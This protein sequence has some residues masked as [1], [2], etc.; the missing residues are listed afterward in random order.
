MCTKSIDIYQHTLFQE[1]VEML[2]YFNILYYIV[3]HYK[4]NFRFET[5]L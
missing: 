4:T 1:V 3:F 2:N 5:N